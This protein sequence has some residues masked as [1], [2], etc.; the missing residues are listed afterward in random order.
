ME[1]LRTFTDSWAGGAVPAE[2]EAACG[3]EDCCK[4]STGAV[5]GEGGKLY[6]VDTFTPYEVSPSYK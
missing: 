6:D 5:A 3:R 4:L 2:A 1:G